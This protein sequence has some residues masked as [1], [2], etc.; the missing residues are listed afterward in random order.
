MKLH[1]FA[2][3]ILVAAS[4][5]V[6]SLRQQPAA[7]TS[8]KVV[9]R[10]TA[11]TVTDTGATGDS[12]GD[13]LTFANEVY[14]EQNATKVGDDN[15]FCFRTVVGAAWECNWTLSLADGQITV[16]G[17][18]YDTKDSVLSIIGGTGMYAN[19]GGQM[20]LH[21]RNAQGSEY[22][23]GYELIGNLMATPTT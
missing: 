20:T 4:F 22:D 13:I 15:G 3:A 21:A 1:L 16:E 7:A 19:A 5:T 18:F 9:E 6:G 8:I 23:F 11:D 17:P 14:D 2:S 12:V 10:A